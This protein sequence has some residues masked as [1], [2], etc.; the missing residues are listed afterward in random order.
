MAEAE[1][2][3]DVMGTRAHVIVSASD[4]DLAELL[5]RAAVARLHA[6]EARWSRF[7]PDS[8]ISAIN[9]E[10]GR[11]VAVSGETVLL[12]ERS[13]EAWHR[14]DGRFD[15]T[16]L[17][18][19]IAAGYDRDFRSVRAANG[20]G[21]HPA[22]ARPTP[23]PGCSGITTGRHE[24]T[25]PPGVGIDPGGIGK[26]LAADLVTD[27]LMTSGADGACINVGGD[28]RVAGRPSD[29]PAWRITLEHALRPE[30]DLGAVSLHDEALVSSWRTRRT[31]GA[32]DDRRHH[33]ID[34][35][36]GAPAWT[37][38]AGV[39]VVA[40]DA[41]WAEALATS[42]F[43]AGPDEAATIVDHHGLDALLV[44]DDGAVRG[45]GRFGPIATSRA[46]R[47]RE[48]PA[49]SEAERR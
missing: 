10:A 9:R 12:V 43:L 40:P 32:E 37:G 46:A 44:R 31:W 3:V 22:P 21:D 36:T 47:V 45:F 1:H 13:V 30:T 41:W 5:G 23:A 14:T 2:L 27:L 39:T 20:S 29:T 35:A 17:P 25:L 7:L 8:E 26:G 24:V 4:L 49:P 19:L 33:L 6:L 42:L 34:P 15:P 48:P 18:A 28:L 11:P 16:I 38:L